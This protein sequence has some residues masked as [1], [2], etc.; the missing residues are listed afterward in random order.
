MVSS[1]GK[2][3]S[4]LVWILIQNDNTDNKVF[5]KE[6]YTKETRKKEREKI[7]SCKLH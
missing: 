4:F 7:S 2:F 1:N 6:F 3:H 5:K